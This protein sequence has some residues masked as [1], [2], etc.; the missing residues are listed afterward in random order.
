[1][2]AD[3]PSV[4]AWAAREDRVLITHD[5]ATL[6]GFAFERIE[7]AESLAGIIAVPQS[8][9]VGDVIDDLALI[10]ECGM[11]EDFRDQLRYLPLR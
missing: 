3:D 4:I 1:M 8:L 11:P 5:V 7:R 2:G 6:I 9:A 10:A